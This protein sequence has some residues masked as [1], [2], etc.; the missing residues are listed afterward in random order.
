MSTLFCRSCSLVRFL[1]I[2]VT[3][4]LPPFT[5]ICDIHC[6]HLC[7]PSSALWG[8]GVHASLGDSS[9]FCSRLTFLRV[10]L[11]LSIDSYFDSVV[12]VAYDPCILVIWIGVHKDTHFMLVFSSMHL[13]RDLF[14]R[15]CWHHGATKARAV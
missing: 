15:I 9:P 12:A 11:V 3:F 6:H 7:P 8:G 4:C 10:N 13:C 5:I 1:C 14:H 2:V